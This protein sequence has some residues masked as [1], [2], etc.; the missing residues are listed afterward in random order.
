MNST[1]RGKIIFMIAVKVG[2]WYICDGKGEGIA[3][4]VTFNPSS[5]HYE[6]FLL[7]LIPV[8]NTFFEYFATFYSLYFSGK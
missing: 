7:K 3:S 2:Q 4:C 5:W 1:K 8:F 6:E